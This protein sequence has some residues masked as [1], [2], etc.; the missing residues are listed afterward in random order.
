M[1]TETKRNRAAVALPLLTGLVVGG[2]A[3][4]QVTASQQFVIIYGELAPTFNAEFN[5]KVALGQ[6]ARLATA[7]FG[8]QYFEVKY[9]IGRPN[10]FNITEVWSSAGSYAA[11]TGA[12][13]T[14][15]MLAN[16]QSWL[17]APLDERD[18]NLV[19]P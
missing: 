16:L 12:S 8:P 1:M 10:L 9:E 15:Q 5:G 7:K 14:Q 17:I 2:G 18:G 4:A 6:L 19:T 11:F 13:N 3:H